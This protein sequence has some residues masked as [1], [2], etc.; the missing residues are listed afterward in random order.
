MFLL[1]YRPTIIKLS[2][3]FFFIFVYSLKNKN[4]YKLLMTCYVELLSNHDDTLK[5][6]KYHPFKTEKLQFL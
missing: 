3:D 6:Q 5:Y 4:N 2:F 1:I